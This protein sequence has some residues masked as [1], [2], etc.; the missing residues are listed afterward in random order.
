MLNSL[1]S[2]PFITCSQK[3]EDNSMIFQLFICKLIKDKC[4]LQNK[5][6]ALRGSIMKFFFWKESKLFKVYVRGGHFMWATLISYIYK[7]HTVTIVHPICVLY[8]YCLNFGHWLFRSWYRKRN[9]TDIVNIKSITKYQL[10]IGMCGSPGIF[11][12]AKFTK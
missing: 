4:L 3:V 11:N 2:L 9:S 5:W 10:D 7:I 6:W 1:F 12:L 8:W